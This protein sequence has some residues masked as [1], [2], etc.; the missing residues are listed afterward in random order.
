MSECMI[1]GCSMDVYRNGFCREHY[2]QMRGYNG[3]GNHNGN[4]GS[5]INTS[6]R[7]HFQAMLLRTEKMLGKTVSLYDKWTTVGTDDAA[8]IYWKN[9]RS[10]YSKGQYEGAAYALEKLIELNPK[11]ANAHYWLGVVGEKMGMYERA[12]YSYEDALELQPDHVDARYR[13]GVLHSRRGD[14]DDATECLEEVI[15][16]SPEHFEGHYRLGLAYDS[17]GD[18]DKA[19][20]SLQKAIEVNPGFTRA[21]QSLGL[22]YD[23]MGMHKK[24]IGFLKKAIELQDNWE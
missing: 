9:A 19:I 6:A 16:L 5:S 13:L 1:K 20:A 2:L 7:F 4:N 21:Y 15:E 12:M 8:E 24:S 17:K 10:Y 3:F 18:Q 23:S 11:D 14:Y 22:V